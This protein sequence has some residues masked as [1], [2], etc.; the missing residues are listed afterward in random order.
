MPAPAVQCSTFLF[1]MTFPVSGVETPFWVPPLVAFVVSFFSS[2]GGISGAVLLLPFQMSV[3]GFTSPAVSATNLVF[4]IIAIPGGVYQYTREGRMIRSLTWVV[5]GGTVPGVVVGQLIRLHWLPD[6][7]PFKAFVGC[8]LLYIAVRIV[9]EIRRP[10]NKAEGGGD[11]HYWAV[12]CVE[13]SIRRLVFDFQGNRYECPTR[14]VFLLSLVVGMVGGI[15]GIGGGAI[16][17]PFFVAH[18]GLPVHTIAGAT[19]MGTFITSVAGVAFSHLIAPYYRGKGMEVAPD[20]QLGS[21]LGVGGMLGVYL[22]ARTQRYMPARWLKIMLAA[23]LM[24]VAVN[25]L[26]GYLSSLG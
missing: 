24:A 10:E 6:P 1:A 9:P 2:M 5:V 15:Y 12:K 22:G 14:F 8:V 3:L 19:L 17:A 18:L 13:C 4:N 7:R 25:Y 16:M 21:L 23:I 26:W 20:W 11:P